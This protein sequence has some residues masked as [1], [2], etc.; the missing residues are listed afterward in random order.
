MMS[1][2]HVE[3]ITSHNAPV[4]KTAQE[5]FKEAQIAKLAEF[6]TGE[7]DDNAEAT[8]EER[9][10]AIYN[11]LEITYTHVGRMIGVKDGN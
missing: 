5:A 6:I 2:Q 8:A 9:A 10:T 1:D 3:E 11:Q 7:W 4:A